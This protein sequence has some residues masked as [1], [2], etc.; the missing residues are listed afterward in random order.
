MD[1]QRFRIADVCQMTEQLYAVDQ[2]G[3]RVFAALDAKTDN[4]SLT[5]RQVFLCACVVRVAGQTRIVDPLDRWML[6]EELGDGQ[7]VLRVPLQP[8]VQRFQ[9]QKGEERSPWA[10]RGA[11]IAQ[12]V[13]TDI[14]DEGDVANGSQRFFKYDSV[15]RRIGRGEFRPLCRILGP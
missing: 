6:F 11:G 7:G 3:A 14:D 15:V 4:R 5:V 1:N 8:N 9:T 10:L 12:P 2:L 13:G